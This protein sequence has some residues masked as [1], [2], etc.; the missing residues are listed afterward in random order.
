[1]SVPEDYTMTRIRRDYLTKLK[2][3]AERNKRS[4]MKQLEVLIDAAEREDQARMRVDYSLGH[5]EDF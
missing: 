2:V 4:V 1:M 3:L 5:S